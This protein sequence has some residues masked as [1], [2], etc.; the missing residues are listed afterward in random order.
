MIE[1][2]N[3]VAFEHGKYTLGFQEIDFNLGVYEEQTSIF[4]LL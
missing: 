4:C 2:W 3:R 1:P